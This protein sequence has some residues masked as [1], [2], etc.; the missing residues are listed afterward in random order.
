M[1]ATS[2]DIWINEFHYDNTGTDENEFV[3]VAYQAGLNIMGYQ[4]VLYSAG[5]QYNTTSLDNAVKTGAGVVRFAVINYITN[6]LQNGP[7]DGFALATSTGGVIQFLSYEGTFLAVDGPANGMMSTDVGVSEVVT[8]PL[9]QSLQLSGT[10]C[11]YTA[12]VW[13]TIATQTK[14]ILNNNQVINC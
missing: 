4:L 14:G 8:P 10:G 2:A 6:G 3:E 13:A 5:L 1:K 7:S 11:G 9:G 12:F